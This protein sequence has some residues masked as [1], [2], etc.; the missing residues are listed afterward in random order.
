MPSSQN[1]SNSR[2]LGSPIDQDTVDLALNAL[3]AFGGELTADQAVRLLP[4]WRY[5]ASLSA[6]EIGAILARY[7]RAGRPERWEPTS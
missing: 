6:E 1:P 2:P 3:R 4:M 5:F 7:P